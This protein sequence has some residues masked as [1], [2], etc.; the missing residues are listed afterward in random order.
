MIKLKLITTMLSMTKL[1]EAMKRV[2]IKLMFEG[3]RLQMNKERDKLEQRI[4]IRGLIL[5]ILKRYFIRNPPK[6]FAIDLTK[7]IKEKYV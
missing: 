2:T 1:H 5:N 7:K 3:E 4:T 6:I